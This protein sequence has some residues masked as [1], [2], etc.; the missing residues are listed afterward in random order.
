MIITE[1]ILRKIIRKALLEAI[2]EGGTN[3]QS[4]YHFT[5]IDS[6]AQILAD[7]YLKTNRWQEDRRNGKRFVSFTRHRSNL[8]GFAYPRELDARIEI[9][10]QKISSVRGNIYPY[11]YYSPDRRWSEI[12]DDY[13]T[14]KTK[15]QDAHA[16]G[17]HRSGE[18]AYMH[19]AEESFETISE[20]LY[21]VDVVKRIDILVPYNLLSRI[22]NFGTKKQTTWINKIRKLLFSKSPLIEVVYVYEN[23]KDFNLQTENCIPL[24]KYFENLIKCAYSSYQNEPAAE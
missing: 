23:E 19:Q 11:E 24:I 9:D 16:N 7:G 18:E 1:T 3:M 8:E 15:Y 14:A 20:K 13:R 4:L 5:S 21:L 12:N 22:E 10:G 6:L 2:E 17:K